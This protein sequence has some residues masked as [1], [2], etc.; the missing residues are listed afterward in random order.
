MSD[1]RGC[2]CFSPLKHLTSANLRSGETGEMWGCFESRGF[3]VNHDLTVDLACGYLMD[4]CG[5]LM[6]AANVA[7][8]DDPAP[9]ARRHRLDGVAV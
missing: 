4:A 2:S 5:Y 1:P 3:C 6:D 8:T 9:P 7:V